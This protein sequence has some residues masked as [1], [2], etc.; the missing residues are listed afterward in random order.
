MT[1]KKGWKLRRLG[2][3]LQGIKFLETTK[4]HYTSSLLRG[5]TLKKSN[6]INDI[7][8]GTA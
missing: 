3:K 1:I 6:F 7:N 4:K 8:G 5:R 2:E